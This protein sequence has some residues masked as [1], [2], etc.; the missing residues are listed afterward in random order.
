MWMRGRARKWT[1]LCNESEDQAN[2]SFASIRSR[3]SPES[4]SFGV[5]EV[6]NRAD[7]HRLRRVRWAEEKIVHVL[8]RVESS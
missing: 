2:G 4:L 8:Y 3:L 6:N 1:D 7:E 5:G